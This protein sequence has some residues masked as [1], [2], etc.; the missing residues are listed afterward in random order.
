MRERTKGF[1]LGAVGLTV[2][3][4]PPLVTTLM[5]FPVWVERSEEA[6]VSGIVC[7][8][9]LLCLVPLYKHIGRMLRSPSAPVMWGIF[10]AVMYIMKSI[11]EQMYIVAVVGVISNVIG[12]LFFKWRDKYKSRE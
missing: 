11:A 4:A 3:T 10:A 8:L 2:S 7:F 12:W 9:G 1:I 6:T 5:Q